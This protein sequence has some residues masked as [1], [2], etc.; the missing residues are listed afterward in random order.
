MSGPLRIGIVGL[1]R[2]GQNHARVLS[3]LAG[4]ELAWTYDL[5]GARAA[6]VAARYGTEAASDLDLALGTVD[7]VIVASPTTAHV[8]H[9]RQALGKVRALFVEKPLTH[10]LPSSL[11]LADEIRAAGAYVQVGFIER[12]NPA[13]RQLKQVIEEGEGSVV[14]IDF[15]R[16]NKISSRITDVDV[17]T[18]LM[19]HDIDLALHLNGPVTKVDALGVAHGAMIDFASAHLTHESG[20]FSRIQASRITDRR[21][22]S[23]EATCTDKFVECDLLRKE[24]T[25]SREA[26][27]RDNVN[28]PYRINTFEEKIEVQQGE[29]LLAELA[30]FAEAVRG[31]V[32]AH[33]PGLDEAVAAMKVCEAIRQ[34]I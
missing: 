4:T 15:A 27:E 20:A 19:I 33:V 26:Q 7:A 10:D 1:G 32:G 31:N 12:F 18:D 17:V 5:D 22:R 23:I 8:D 30:A 29:S 9:V 25:C 34:A 14:S 2:M 6:E 13:V 11:V 21:K 3:L 28:G 16:T 24:I